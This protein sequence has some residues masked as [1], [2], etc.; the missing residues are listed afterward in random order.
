MN[1]AVDVEKAEPEEVC[2]VRARNQFVVRFVH[3]VAEM[4]FDEVG[5]LCAVVKFVVIARISIYH[6]AN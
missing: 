3:I 6:R 5:S 2:L 1:P 4:F